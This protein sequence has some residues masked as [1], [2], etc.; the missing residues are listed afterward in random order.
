M[1][2]QII[3]FAVSFG[4]TTVMFALLYKVVPDVNIAWRDVWV[5]AIITSIF[6]TIGKQLIGLY[7]GRASVASA[8]GAA[9]SLVI[10][11]LWVYYSA[12]ILFLGAEFTQVY[13]RMFGSRRDERAMLTTRPGEG[14]GGAAKSRAAHA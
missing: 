7:L 8:Y 3:N 14:A 6:F 1:W 10:V 4:L 13:A 9:G 11:M 2:G 5:G 12:Q